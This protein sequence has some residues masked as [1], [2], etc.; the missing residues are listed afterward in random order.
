MKKLMVVKHCYAVVDQFKPWIGFSSVV[1]IVLGLVLALAVAPTDYQQGDAYRIIFIHVPAAA[2]S[3]VV[4]LIMSVAALIYLVWKIK[5]AD[6]IAKVS[7]PLGAMFTFITL[8][9]GAIWGRPTWG[10][11]W[12]WDARLTSELI[13]LFIYLGIIAFRSVIPDHRLAGRACG[14][15][16]LVGMVNIPIIHYSVQWWHTLHQGATVFKFS[17]PNMAPVM[18][19]PLY[20]M[21]SAYFLFYLYLLF[22]RLQ[23]EIIKRQKE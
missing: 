15:L 17:K 5:I 10:T 7:A 14:L 2:L 11:Y 13:L 20:V 21:L 16:T 4:Y 6:M 12:I 22:I 8:V 3:L 9:T 23:S 18:L 1:L 19:Y